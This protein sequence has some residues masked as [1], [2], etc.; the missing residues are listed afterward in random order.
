VREKLSELGANP[1]ANSPAEMDR[2]LRD[3]RER[4]ATLIRAANL[5]IEQ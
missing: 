1:I 5:K 3:E 2:F 4:W